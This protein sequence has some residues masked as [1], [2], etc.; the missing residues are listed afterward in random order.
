MNVL[1]GAIKNGQM[2]LDEPAE[3]PEG[4]WVEALP[5]EAAWPTLGMRE[6]D[7]PTTPEGIAALLA[8]MD[9][10]EPMR[11]GGCGNDSVPARHRQC[12]GYHQPPP[13][14]LTSIPHPQRSQFVRS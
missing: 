2:V 12:W 14:R 4:S 5:V 11:W 7:W 9:R 8:R 3:L 1:Q 6:E 13:R 10:V